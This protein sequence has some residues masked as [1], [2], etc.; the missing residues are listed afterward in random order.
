MHFTFSW[1]DPPSPFQVETD[2][3]LYVDCHVHGRAG[4]EG[5]RAVGIHSRVWRER[6]LT[7]CFPA[8]VR[9]RGQSEGSQRFGG[10]PMWIPSF[11]QVVRRIQG[12][13]CLSASPWC[14]ERL[15][16]RSFC[17]R[18][19]NMCRTTRGS[20]PACMESQK[21]GPAWPTWSPSITEGPVRWM[22]ERLLM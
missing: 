5:G 10:L 6:W 9:V 20:G 17:L 13:T 3:L 21:S 16:S 4:G 1:S 12:T 15:S 7:S 18:L 2:L 8:S 22:R 14:Q 19:H 11:R